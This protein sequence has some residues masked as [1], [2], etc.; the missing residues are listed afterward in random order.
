MLKVPE[1]VPDPGWTKTLSKHRFK[2]KYS[3]PVEPYPAATG[4]VAVIGG[5]ESI[6]MVVLVRGQ[7]TS[8]DIW[9]DFV[10]MK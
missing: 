3:L 2:N 6:V 9:A 4:S 5:V 10:R 8:V 7:R 1:S